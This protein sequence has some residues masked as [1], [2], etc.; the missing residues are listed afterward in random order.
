MVARRGFLKMKAGIGAGL[1]L[2]LPF[3]VKNRTTQVR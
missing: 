2:P 1:F 3:A